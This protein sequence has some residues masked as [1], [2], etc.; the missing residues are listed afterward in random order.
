MKKSFFITLSGILF[1]FLL[2]AQQESG[3]FYYYFGEKIF[4]KSRTDKIFLRF[5]PDADSE[6]LR[7]LIGSD[8]SLQPIDSKTHLETGR[9]SR[10][11][12]LAAKDGKHIPLSAV[13][14]LK[15]NTD[16]NFLNS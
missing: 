13:H 4:L 16:Y 3:D 5:T 15:S 1:S 2:N 10:S 6:Y 12:I 7:S 11:T 8:V 14:L 9:V